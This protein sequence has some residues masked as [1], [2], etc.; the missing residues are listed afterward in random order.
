MHGP[1]GTVGASHRR[2]AAPRRSV[3]GGRAGPLARQQGRQA[4]VRGA[5]VGLQGQQLGPQLVDALVALGRRLSLL[6]SSVTPNS[7]ASEPARMPSTA[8]PVNMIPVATTRP[9]VVRW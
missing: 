1:D 3:A 4:R 6:F 7:D 5:H 2:P 9:V 8:T